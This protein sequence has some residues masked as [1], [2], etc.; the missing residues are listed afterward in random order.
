MYLQHQKNKT[1][2]VCTFEFLAFF[3]RYFIGT[4]WF[5]KGSGIFFISVIQ[6]D[7]SIDN[8]VSGRLINFN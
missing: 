7:P 5:E 2:A 4:L 8:C 3:T 1:S 6:L